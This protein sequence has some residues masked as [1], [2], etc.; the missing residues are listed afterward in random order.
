[1]EELTLQIKMN[2]KLFL[3]NPEDTELGREILKNSII[4]IHKTGFEAFTFKK[5]AEETGT[6]EA[7]VYRYFENKHRLLV[8]IV[9]WYWSWLEYK[10]SVHTQ[11]IENPE[12]KLK[13]A[14]HIL[15]T[16]VKD[17]VKTKHVD[18]RLLYEVVVLEG[19][20]AYLNR[21][22]S[23]DNKHRFFK[24]YKD[25]CTSVAAIISQCNPKYKYPRSLATTI[26]EMA[27]FQNFFLRNLPSL[28]DFGNSKDESKVIKFLEDLVF[29][30][31]F[32][33]KSK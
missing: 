28:T 5:L 18:E 9:S 26:I 11:N 7:S 20:K 6:T 22:V 12:I 31:L 10:I 23:E 4:L 21:H 8:Y 29:S 24:P 16:M 13:K 3:R 15:S 2:E 30:S 19:V 27:H 33:N 1:M 14:L 25:L 17:D 32:S